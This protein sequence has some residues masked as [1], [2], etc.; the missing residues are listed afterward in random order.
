MGS[1]APVARAAPV[2]VACATPLLAAAANSVFPA[3]NKPK[4]APPC[5]H[6]PPASIEIKTGVP[7]P[8]L[9]RGRDSESAYDKP[10]REMKVGDN[11]ELTSA[12]AYAMQSRAKRF[13]V[14]LTR[15]TLENGNVGLWR[16]K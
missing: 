2:A 11:V 10:L 12:Q 14:K 3:V 15:R 7:L 4:R 6:E 13:G 1:G 16:V 5:K 8:V 9:R